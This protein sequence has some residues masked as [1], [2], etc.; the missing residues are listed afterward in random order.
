VAVA[1]FDVTGTLVDSACSQ[2]K[3]QQ[4]QGQDAMTCNSE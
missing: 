4:A 1:L 3:R 2:D